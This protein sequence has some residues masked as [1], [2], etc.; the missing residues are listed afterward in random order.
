[1]NSNFPVMSESTTQI[2]STRIADLNHAALSKLVINHDGK[3]MTTSL[4]VAEVFGKR[5]DNVL[6]DIEALDCSESFRALNFEETGIEVQA[7]PVKRMSKVYLMTRDGFT[8]LAMG[9][10]GAKA[11]EFKEKYIAEFNRMEARIKQN[12]ML[13]I[14]NFEN[15]VEAARAWADQM[16]KRQALEA[17]TAI[18]AP[19]AEVYDAVVA[20]KM[21]KVHQ[22]ARSLNGTNSRQTKWDLWRAGY[23]YRQRG[24]YRVYSKYRD[25]YFME[26]IDPST[27]K[28]DIYVTD[29]GKCEI[30]KLY[31]RGILTMK[32]A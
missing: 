15:P 24:G 18:M 23:L 19:K 20:D 4:T 7:G 32:G 9:F 8:F 6:R 12:Q 11:A 27:G 28:T 17:Q 22:F 30:A 21:M 13:A 29:A 26:K 5:H 14:P 16:E 25:K 10:N 31:N 1:M 3:P 2:P